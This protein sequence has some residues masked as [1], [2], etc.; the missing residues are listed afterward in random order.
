METWGFVG[1]IIVAAFLWPLSWIGFI[2]LTL[3]YFLILITELINTAVEQ[4]LERIHPERHDLIGKS[5][6]IASSAVFMA[7]VFAAVVIVTLF[8]SKF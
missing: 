4:M 2:L 1:F 6:D 7:F 5:K 3:S 8:W